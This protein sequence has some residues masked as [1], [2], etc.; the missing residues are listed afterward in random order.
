MRSRLRIELAAPIAWILALAPA[1]SAR[2]E[3]TA[4]AESPPTVA[5]TVIVHLKDGGAYRG[6]LLSEQADVAVVIRTAT[7]KERR[8][9]MGDVERVERLAPPPAPVQAAQSPTPVQAA[10]PPAPVQAAPAA[11]ASG[12][13]PVWKAVGAGRPKEPPVTAQPTPTPAAPTPAPVVVQPAAPTP[14]PVVVQPAAPAPAPAVIL[15]ASKPAPAPVIAPQAAAAPVATPLPPIARPAP[16]PPIARPAPVAS[17]AAAAPLS[18]ASGPVSW[19]SMARAKEA[20]PL[21]RT[22]PMTAELMPLPPPPGFGRPPAAVAE[23]QQ[24][25]GSF[26]EPPP[27][28]LP[29]ADPAPAAAVATNGEAPAPTWKAAGPKKRGTPAVE[30]KPQAPAVR[31]AAVAVAPAPAP[32]AQAAPGA[33]AW[34]P[35]PLP[36]DG[37]GAAPEKP[38]EGEWSYDVDKTGIAVGFDQTL[39]SDSVRKSWAESGGT[40]SGSEVG[41]GVSFMALTKDFGIGT[42]TMSGTGFQVSLGLSSLSLTPPDYETRG[43]SWTAWKVGVGTEVA[44]FSFTNTISSSYLGSSTTTGQMTQLTI[45][46]CIGFLRATGSFDSETDWSGFAIGIDWVPSI[47][48]TTT[49]VGGSSVSS[50]P[51]LNVT[52]FALNFESGSMKAMAETMA[53]E[54]KFKLRLFLLPPVGDLPLFFS[55]SAG[56][57]WY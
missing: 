11:R 19:P 46:G 9:E 53:K 31:S 26:S 54:A 25:T 16:V 42:M 2:A 37:G 52:G 28:A 8:F 43:T 24:A 13:G 7:G 48:K 41:L 17:P 15:P 56:W 3:A 51:T 1:M 40:L 44:S 30:P 4:A 50:D 21:P 55:I 33:P 34:E 20:R 32:A 10:P 18:P 27:A 57:V 45:N 14:A 49:T 47:V 29:P 12:G 36:P 5:N 35:P 23:R 38:K 39:E 22:S 6:T